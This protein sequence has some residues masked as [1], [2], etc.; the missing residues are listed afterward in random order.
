MKITFYHSTLCPRCYLA[1]RILLDILQD[2]Q[3][4]LIEEID[5]LAHPLRT[6]SDGIRVFPALKIGDRILG[7]ILPSRNK[8]LA[9]IQEN[10]SPVTAPETASR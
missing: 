9:F 4:I 5:V 8:M 6:W 10:R 2:S 1:R 7:S 3:D